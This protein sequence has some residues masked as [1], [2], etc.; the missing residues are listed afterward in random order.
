MRLLTAHKILIG[1]GVVLGVLMIAWGAVH[2]LLRHE[3][4][5]WVALVL[6]V[7]MVPLGLLY[8]RRLMKNPPI[9]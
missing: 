9:H 1:A 8:L 4:D 2:G 7:G 6:G 3:P 5:A